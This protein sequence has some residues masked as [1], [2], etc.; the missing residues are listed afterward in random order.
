MFLDAADE[1]A[2][3]NCGGRQYGTAPDTHGK[4]LAPLHCPGC[5]TR[6]YGLW[7]GGSSP[8]CNKCV[9]NRSIAVILRQ[10]PDM[11]RARRR[12]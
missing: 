6:V 3:R 12:W 8:T 11:A 9:N 10:T 5:G 7:S 1:W 2:C 4:K